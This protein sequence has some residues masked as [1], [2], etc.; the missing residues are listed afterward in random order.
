MRNLWALLFC[1]ALSSLVLAQNTSSTSSSPWRYP[2]I[3]RGDKATATAA[4]I[5]ISVGYSYLR[6]NGSP[7]HCGCFHMDGGSTEVAIHL[8]R[9]FS[10]VAD[11]TGERSGSVNGGSQ[12]LSL[13]SYTAGPRFTYPIHHCYAPFAQALFGGV[14]SFD[15]YFPVASGPAG[16]ANSFAML[17]GGGLDL[18]VKPWLAIRP[19]HAD[20]FLTK[21][22][23]G[24]ND[25]QNS[26]RLSVA[27]VLR[28][29]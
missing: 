1:C 2:N 6:T 15:S 9:W 19:V 13:V 16:A 11:V 22:P 3:Y 18:R 7:G 20:Y 8:Y 23:N 12:G 10:N 29:W 26:L 4:P 17:V 28:L 24:I 27:V 25:R 14:H 5:E 21:L